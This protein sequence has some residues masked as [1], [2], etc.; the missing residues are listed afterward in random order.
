MRA[1][2]SRPSN[3][4]A[5]TFVVVPEGLCEIWRSLMT[6]SPIPLVPV[7]IGMC[8]GIP[9]GLAVRRWIG[10]DMPSRKVRMTAVVVVIAVWVLMT[11]DAREPLWRFIFG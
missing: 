8:I 2:P 7:V 9:V 6:M 3:F 10:K 5:R 4:W 11:R 1:P